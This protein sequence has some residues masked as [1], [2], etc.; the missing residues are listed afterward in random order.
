MDAEAH[1]IEGTINH[2]RKTMAKRPKTKDQE[3]PML[4]L[5]ERFRQAEQYQLHLDEPKQPIQPYACIGYCPACPHCREG[6]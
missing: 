4:P 5:D 1:H 6:R 2:G 3:E